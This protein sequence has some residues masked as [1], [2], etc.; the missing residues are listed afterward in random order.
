[1]Y[2][3]DEMQQQ[4]RPVTLRMIQQV[5]ELW[6]SDRSAQLR[7]LERPEF[8]SVLE[9]EPERVRT[10][11]VDAAEF[12]RVFDVLVH[13]EAEFDRK[14]KESQCYDHLS[15]RWEMNKG[16]KRHFVT[17]VLP[18]SGTNAK[19]ACGDEVLLSHPGTS[20]HSS[21]TAS[22]YIV[23]I[24]NNINDDITIEL[25]P[26]ASNHSAPPTDITTQFKLE[27]VWKATTYDRMRHALHEFLRCSERK[28]SPMSAYLMHKL[29]GHDIDD[30]GNVWFSDDS[31]DISFPMTTNNGNVHINNSHL[32]PTVDAS[33]SHWNDTN[34]KTP[35]IAAT[36]TITLEDAPPLHY[37][38]L[39]RVVSNVRAEFFP[40]TTTHTKTT[41]PAPRL[42][43]RIA[44]PSFMNQPLRERS[45]VP[46]LP[47]LNPSQ[48][49]AVASALTQPL[50]LI[51]GPP[52]TGKTVTSAAIVY[53]VVQRH[54]HDKVL[55]CAPSNV[56]VDHLTEKIHAIGL[57]VLRLCAKSREAVDS[58][59]RAL[60]LHEQLRSYMLEIIRNEDRPQGA[61]K[62]DSSF[63]STSSAAVP[64]LSSSSRKIKKDD[65]LSPALLAILRVKANNDLALVSQRDERMYSK[66]KR[67][68]ERA[69]L[70][71]AEVICC[72][73]TVAG[74]AR[75]H[76]VRFRTVLL[77]EATQATEPEALI[78]L[79]CGA[80]QAVMVGDHQ[81]LGPVIMEKTAARAGFG[82][83]L[84]ER[85][86]SLG[87]R[88]TRLQVQYRMHPCLSQ[89]PSNMFYEGSLQNGI[90]ELDRFWPSID[91][92]WPTSASRPMTFW[93]SLG[94]E[95]LSSSGT[96]YLN[97]TEA[98]HCEKAISRLLNAGVLPSQVGV[99]TPYE[100]QRTYLVHYLQTYGD[101]RPEIYAELEIASV[102]AFQGREK[103]FIILSCVR[104]NE[105]Q[106]IG[107][108][109]D[110]RRL[111]VAL[112]RAR[113]GL[114]VLG[115]PRALS[116]HPLWHFL[117]LHYREYH[118]LVEG[119]LGHLRPYG[120]TLSRPRHVHR[121]ANYMAMMMMSIEEMEVE[122]DGKTTLSSSISSSS[123]S[124]TTTTLLSASAL[125][126]TSTS[127]STAT[128]TSTQLSH[129]ELEFNRYRNPLA[130]LFADESSR[131]FTR[132]IIRASVAPRKL[133]SMN[134]GM[135]AKNVTSV[136]SRLEEDR[137]SEL[138]SQASLHSDSED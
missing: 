52:G 107:F 69:L 17:F 82:Q 76:R 51:Q 23:K 92:P 9:R 4:A 13:L 18:R 39:D 133:P 105:H 117:L 12:V 8:A 118:C 40:E 83:S 67:E 55:V 41:R 68:T 98:A 62:E 61:K 126:S 31:Q 7:D 42:L 102:D 30:E 50:S 65:P 94:A 45:T 86:V 1:M 123:S 22:G 60:T 66:W 48:W 14:L 34:S 99:I 2:P 5:E 72:T 6:K 109:N 49:Q 135:R 112:T 136:G 43:A 116:K 120:G 137:L 138:R 129:G 93:A 46:P 75:L 106:G 90:T 26:T 132:D 81:Q 125:S 32:P 122:E 20:Q 111:N 38:R 88:P 58:S 114:I 19:F 131:R 54:P 77:D 80:L 115:N 130:S 95:E 87:N 37:Q 10:R 44:L 128:A 124:T 57:R 59:V 119:T 73:C 127:T 97:R 71:H 104:S 24:P 91:F 103:D 78:P 74:D 70:R 89:F 16:E 35:K 110:P 21:W 25:Q 53:H 33:R 36:S 28:D 15:I 85:L 27:F 134:R 29:L 64:P 113:Y 84:F 121:Y 3:T 79:M 63:L 11:Y 56:A 47:A 100:G 101:L 108:L 96:S